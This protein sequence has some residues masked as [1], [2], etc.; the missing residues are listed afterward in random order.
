M[1]DEE[2]A[3]QDCFRPVRF[4]LNGPDD[5]EVMRARSQCIDQEP[6]EA[7]GAEWNRDHPFNAWLGSTEDF[8]AHNL[9]REPFHGPAGTATDRFARYLSLDRFRQLLLW[10]NVPQSLLTLYDRRQNV[11]APTHV[12]RADDQSLVDPFKLTRKLLCDGHSVAVRTMEGIDPEVARLRDDVARWTGRTA[13][14][15]GYYTPGKTQTFKWHW[16]NH[17]VFVFHIHGE[18]EWKIYDPVVR[19]PLQKQR[20]FN[21]PGPKTSLR[22]TIVLRPGDLLYLPAGFPHHASATSD[23]A[24]LHLTVGVYAPTYYDVVSALAR[25]GVSRLEVDPEVREQL[26]PGRSDL[27]TPERLERVRIMLDRMTSSL[28]VREA[29]YLYPSLSGC[30][31]THTPR[32]AERYWQ[33]I[34]RLGTLQSSSRV[35][36]RAPL[37]LRD[38]PDRVGLLCGEDGL[39]FETDLRPALRFISETSEFLISDVPDLPPTERLRLVG[40]LIEEAFLLHVD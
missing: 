32:V 20:Y 12:S 6:R 36:R 4:S 23:L 26:P 15:N 27:F 25:V 9:G 8:V 31:E 11:V 14:V 18:K 2:R 3:G 13:Q 5:P 39:L 37:T 16:D 35:G 24:S 30:R 34:S 38:F 1:F 17:D 28:H 29:R 40:R 7:L 33:S 10:N 21:W 22:T 19:H